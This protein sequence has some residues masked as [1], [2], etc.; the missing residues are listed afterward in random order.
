M[1]RW[2]LLILAGLVSGCP[3]KKTQEATTSSAPAAQMDTYIPTD[4]EQEQ[5]RDNVAKG[6]LGDSTMFPYVY[7]GEG[8]SLIYQAYTMSFTLET[9]MA[10]AAMMNQNVPWVKPEANNE[11]NGVFAT[12]IR[13]GRE[14][15]LDNPYI[16]VQYISK[17]LPYCSTLDSVFLWMDQ[18]FLQNPQA[19]IMQKRTS[20]QTASGKTAFYKAYTTGS[21][22]NPAYRQ[23]WIANAYI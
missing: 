19:E 18:N 21:N 5:I 1:N 22:P 23:K 4:E 16:Q 7:Q 3:A 17:G 2:I 9:Q 8:R 15:S 11:K 14:L 20:I 10:L 12:Y 13:N 6:L